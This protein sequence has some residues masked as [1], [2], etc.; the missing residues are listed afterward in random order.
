[1][2][3]ANAYELRR[4]LGDINFTSLFKESIGYNYNW[5][6]ISLENTNKVC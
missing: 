2:I 5:G 3:N 4:D 1:M 6:N